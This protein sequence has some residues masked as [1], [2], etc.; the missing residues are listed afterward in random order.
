M[1]YEDITKGDVKRVEQISGVQIKDKSM[2]REGRLLEE[3]PYVKKVF[4][5]MVEPDSKL[6]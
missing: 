6:R 2:I 1:S 3:I 5:D 4:E